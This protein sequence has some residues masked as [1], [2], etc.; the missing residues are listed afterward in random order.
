[1]KKLLLFITSI[2]IATLSYADNIVVYDN[3]EQASKASGVVM[4]TPPQ[5][6]RLADSNQLRP[7]V[8]IMVVGKGKHEFPP[9]MNLTTELFNGSLKDYLKIVKEINDAQGSEWKN[10]GSIRTTAGEASLSQADTHTEWGDVRMMHVILLKD[11]TIY[12]LTAAA[13][14]EEFPNFYK[15]FFNSMRSLSV[16][17]GSS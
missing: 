9:S 12:I 1:M 2:A 7:S 14:R 11:E 17:D 13:L 10:L 5:G 3:E 8:K 6:W 15:E 16:Q 4:F